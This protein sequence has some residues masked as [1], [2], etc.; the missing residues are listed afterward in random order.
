[1]QTV[2]LVWQVVHKDN[3]NSY[4]VVIADQEP[5]LSS[6]PVART[7]TGK[8][9]LSELKNELNHVELAME[10][11]Q[12]QRESLTRWVTTRPAVNLI[13]QPAPFEQ[14]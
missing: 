4:V 10:D 2:D 9:P 13:H 14:Q 7:H 12:A 5:P 6:M 3:L 8:I 1:M 11:L